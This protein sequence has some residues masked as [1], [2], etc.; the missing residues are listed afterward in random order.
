MRSAKDR[1]ALDLGVS[2]I[3]GTFAHI[4]GLVRDDG[5]AFAEAIGHFE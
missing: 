4:Q 2:S 1:A 3:A 5:D